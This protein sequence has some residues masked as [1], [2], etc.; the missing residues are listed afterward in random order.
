MA[1]L[2]RVQN[3]VDRFVPELSLSY[4]ER[5]KLYVIRVNNID[6]NIFQKIN[7]IL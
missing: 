5:L 6:K 1:P 3:T 7:W 4:P 2:Q